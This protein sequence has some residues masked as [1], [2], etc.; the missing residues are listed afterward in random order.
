MNK[1]TYFICVLLL[2]VFNIS[3]GQTVIPPSPESSALIRSINIPV[4]HYT[5]TASI[6]V[7]LMNIQS[8]GINIPI[9]LSYQTSGIKVQDIAPWTGL[10]WNLSAG[11]KITRLVRGKPDEGGYCKEDGRAASQSWNEEKYISRLVSDFDGQPDI[12]YFQLPGRS[13]MFVCNYNGKAYTIPYQ[14]IEIEWV[15]KKYWV[16]TDENGCKYYFGNTSAEREITKATSIDKKI[17]GGGGLSGATES[18]ANAIWGE[19]YEKSGVTSEMY[20][21]ST[22]HL[23]KI[24]SS[25][26]ESVELEYIKGKAIEYKMYNWRKSC[27]GVQWD[28]YIS[29]IEWYK[30]SD[31][32]TTIHIE[33]PKYLNRIIYSG[34]DVLFNSLDNRLDLTGARRLDAIIKKDRN[35]AVSDK[36]ELKYN[37][38]LSCDGSTAKRLKLEE[39][40]RIANNG[41][42]IPISR[43]EYYGTGLPERNSKDFDHWGY[44]NS[45]GNI[46]FFPVTDIVGNL[47]NVDRSASF[48][49]TIS[50]SLKK[51][52]FNTGGHK[53]FIYELNDGYYTSGQQT[54][55][56]KVGGLRI[57]TIK[58]YE[59]KFSTPLIINYR[60]EKEENGV[61]MSSGEVFNPKTEYYMFMGD[62]LDNGTPK[63]AGYIYSS[64]YENLFDVMGAPVGYTNI[65]E[66]CSSGGETHYSYI[67]YSEINDI[68][69]EQYNVV[70]Q[71]CI[72][73]ETNLI[74]QGIQST[75]NFWKRGLLQEIKVYDS[76]KKLLSRKRT[77][78]KYDSPLK[79]KIA[80]Y[81]LAPE[82]IASSVAED[83][84]KRLFYKYYWISQPLYQICDSISGS[85]VLEASN[86]YVYDEDYLV[87]VKVTSKNAENEV[88]EKEIYYPFNYNVLDVVEQNIEGMA[89]RTMLERH[90]FNIPIEKITSKN[91]KVI[92]AELN[93]FKVVNPMPDDNIVVSDSHYKMFTDMPISSGF[94]RYMV[95]GT[96]TEK[97]S[98]YKLISKSDNYCNNGKLKQYH[99]NN[100][101]D[102]SYIYGYN[103]TL[104]IAEVINAKSSI[105]HREGF[106]IYKYV[107]FSKG[108]I[109]SATKLFSLQYDQAVKVSL[110]NIVY[111][112][113][114][115]VNE[116]EVLIEIKDLNGIS[117]WTDYLSLNNK[118]LVSPVLKEGNY[119]LDILSLGQLSFSLEIFYKGF[120]SVYNRTNEVFYTS[121]EDVNDAISLSS[122]KTGSK[123]CKKQ[124]SIETRDFIPGSYFLSYWKSYDGI[125][126]TNIEQTINI[127]SNTNSYSLGSTSYYIDELRLLPKDAGI[128]TFTYK[129][130][131]GKSSETDNNGITTYYQYDV[132]GRLKR[133]LDN[134]R[135]VIKEYDYKYAN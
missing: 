117:V 127:S 31:I 44:C 81:V 22:W 8:G 30:D 110:E 113:G 109:S 123:A 93:T 3:N 56:M 11:G 84:L 97:D 85:Q 63:G 124:F 59:N 122:A 118:M 79:Q 86:T 116:R 46:S 119:S 14:N 77:K 132:F 15:D 80:A 40:N 19:D 104:P 129:E 4:N 55:Y 53:E 61:V 54:H 21:T 90:M 108:T 112:T 52:Y 133:V 33:E 71:Y 51:V 115:P 28:A 64:S 65:I 27:I 67:S 35:E 13:G 62:I 23:S 125:N 1:K 24:V 120:Q 12:F 96:N 43:F 69:P 114:D 9:S 131:V 57:K 66:E 72:D 74:K 68:E 102:I 111:S 91:N 107:D 87:P 121:F 32:S 7:P 6:G 95:S 10:G 37:Y 100:D 126:W 82:V 94:N 78:Y 134:D 26:N 70:D 128:T 38:F 76:N 42:I 75:S 29:D 99:I 88:V 130:N 83:H 18:I 92:D 106:N 20:Y 103:N 49:N 60:Y 5:G 45:G 41:E 89:I 105:P 101:V 16:I 48:Y 47:L 34:G 25:E 39:I 73:L 58:E 17:A 36:I 2:G 50:S 98:R 135:N